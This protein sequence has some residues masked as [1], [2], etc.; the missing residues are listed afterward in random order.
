MLAWS[1]ITGDA[2]AEGAAAPGKAFSA[3]WNR[4]H[5][6]Y[7]SASLSNCSGDEHQVATPK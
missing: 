2:M 6:S 4:R 3:F 5:V 1:P 7:P